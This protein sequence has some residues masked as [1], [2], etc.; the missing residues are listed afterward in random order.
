MSNPT[1][2]I[3]S[4]DG[5]VVMENKTKPASVS[6]VVELPYHPLLLLPPSEK[7]R[8]SI[9]QLGRS[10]PSDLMSATNIALAKEVLNETP[11]DDMDS[12]PIAEAILSIL[13]PV[14]IAMVAILIYLII[15]NASNSEY[16]K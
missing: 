10:P 3:R 14:F 4:T 16:E 13:P 1:Y 6:E 11:N 5:H 7:Q 2:D 9:K 15:S 12:Y 8:E